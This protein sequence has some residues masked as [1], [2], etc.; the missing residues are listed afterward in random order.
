MPEIK[1]YDPAIKHLGATKGQLVK[2]TRDSETQPGYKS[3]TYRVV[4]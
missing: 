4:V 3:I 2:I 1:F